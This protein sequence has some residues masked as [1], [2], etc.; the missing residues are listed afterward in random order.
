MNRV[1]G[2][3][4]WSDMAGDDA[5]AD[6][7]VEKIMAGTM[8]ALSRQGAQK[9]S[10]SDIC[11]ASGVARG[12]FYRYFTSKEEVL[13][14][15][16]SHLEDGAAEAFATAIEAN[17]DPSARVQVVLDTI[18]AYRAAEGDFARMLEVAP[19]FTLEFIRD[20]F[21]KLVGTVTDALGAVLTESPLV[22]SGALTERQLGDL[23][24]RSVMSML[25]LPGSR[26][27]EVPA[28]VA[29]LFNV[30]MGVATKAARKRSTRAKA[31]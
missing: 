22:T 16:G 28:M 20:T 18:V 27:D 6:R 31:S 12:T 25:F 30:D 17:P 7:S 10:V 24:V 13:A 15:L 5:R 23:F 11:A 9:L 3:V 29:S 26:S 2:W 14:T 8:K 19:E 1:F 21:P 4:G